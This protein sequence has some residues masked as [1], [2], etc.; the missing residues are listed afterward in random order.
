MNIDRDENRQNKAASVVDATLYSYIT[1][2]ATHAI[3]SLSKNVTGNPISTGS[4]NEDSTCVGCDC[5]KRKLSQISNLAE[6]ILTSNNI[7]RNKYMKCSTYIKTGAALIAKK[8]HNSL[9][10]AMKYNE[11]P[12]LK[13]RAIHVT[14]GMVKLQS[15]IKQQTGKHPCHPITSTATDVDTVNDKTPQEIICPIPTPNHIVSPYSSITNAPLGIPSF[16]LPIPI[17]GETYTPL[18]ACEIL[19]N[20]CDGRSKIMLDMPINRRGQHPIK[21]LSNSTLVALM[22]SMEY[23]PIKRT[24]MFVLLKEYKSNRALKYPHSWFDTSK[25]GR[26]AALDDEVVTDL[27]ENY[28]SKTVGGATVSK[29]N[30]TENLTSLIKKQFLHNTNKEYVSE[31][32]PETTMRKY[33]NNIQSIPTM[34]TMNNVSNKTESRA[35]SEFSI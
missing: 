25:S 19:L 17:N 3:A 30:L 11:I 24:Q 29:A 4:N 20:L 16:K 8:E 12:I 28:H 23:I 13:Q 1:D 2:D 32:I 15:A 9:K 34:N 10:R 33:V 22:I 35:A 14:P 27:I 18:K 26:K 21:Q 7:Q 5:K 6:T 31:I